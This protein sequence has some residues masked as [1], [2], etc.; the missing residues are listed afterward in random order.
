MRGPNLS[1]LV[2]K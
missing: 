2:C 1:L